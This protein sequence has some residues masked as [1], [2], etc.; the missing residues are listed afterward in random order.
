MLG[1]PYGNTHMFINMPNIHMLSES[2]PV[3]SCWNICS[4]LCHSE[5]APQAMITPVELTTSALSNESRHGETYLL[6]R[7][8]VWTS[9]IFH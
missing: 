1:I 4:A 5:A 8:Q 9:M 3:S 7:E 6:C 2:P